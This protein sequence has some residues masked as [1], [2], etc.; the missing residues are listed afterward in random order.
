MFLQQLVN[1]ISIG[2]I[3][4]LMATGYALIYSLLG[5]SNWA[6][7]DVAMLGAYI[8]FLCVASAKLPFYLSCIAAILG[9]GLISI[10]N[11]RLAYRQIRKNKAPTM[12]LMIAAMGLSVTFQNMVIVFIG[13]KFRT[14][15]PVIPVKAIAI[16]NIK[17]GVLDLISLCIVLIAVILLEFLINKTKFGL[18]VRAASTNLNTASLMGINIDYYIALVFFLAGSL[19]G[20]AGVLLG[21]KY[22]V[23]P[24]MGNVSLKAFIASVFGGLGSVRGA[25]IGA[26][27]IGIMEVFIS[28]FVISGLR[29]L[30]TFGLLIAI[31]LFKPTGLFGIE[32]QDKA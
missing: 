24:Q 28:G 20:A 29:D 17:L 18:A 26:L 5:F 6:H 8:G 10:M 1:G 23:Y 2:G 13:P 11:E 21:L 30:F 19:A 32:V 12:F 14:F 22:T 15:P 25:I 3:Y 31:L 7:G 16:G 27:I 9:A 4:A